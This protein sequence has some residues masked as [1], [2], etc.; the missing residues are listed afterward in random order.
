MQVI[1][2]Y[3]Q[4][5]FLIYFCDFLLLLMYYNYCIIRAYVIQL[6]HED[7]NN[8]IRLNNMCGAFS[9][10]CRNMVILTNH[11]EFLICCVMS[12]YF[13]TFDYF[14]IHFYRDFIFNHHFMV[15]I[16]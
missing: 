11:T 7:I 14:Q 6:L 5:L 15:F 1:T 9:M 10:F 13:K 12:H 8:K 2:V 16:K 3:D 4:T